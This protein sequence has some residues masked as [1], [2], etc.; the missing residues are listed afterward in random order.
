MSFDKAIL[1][2]S[3]IK[4]HH[5]FYHFTFVSSLGNITCKS[6]EGMRQIFDI[7]QFIYCLRSK[8]ILQYD[9]DTYRKDDNNY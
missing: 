9:N 2:N 4:F 8:I 3:H 6:C 1:N 7:M 5:N